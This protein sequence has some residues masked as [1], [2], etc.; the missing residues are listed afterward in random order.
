[1]FR[2]EEDL[3]AFNELVR[4]DDLS[5]RGLGAGRIEHSYE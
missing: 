2:L 1:M 3:S 4:E 5:W